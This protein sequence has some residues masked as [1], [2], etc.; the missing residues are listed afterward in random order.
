MQY[1]ILISFVT[2]LTF[3]S[4]SISK[5]GLPASY[6]ALSARWMEWCPAAGLPLWSVV[7]CL[8]AAL[9][10]PVLLE[11]GEGSALQFLGF[12]CPL[13]LIIVSLTPRW[14][15]DKRQYRV[16]V[17]GAALCAVCG[18]AWIVV[19]KGLWLAVA[20][21]LAVALVAALLTKTLRTSLVLW[22]EYVMFAGMYLSL[23]LEYL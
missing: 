6:S 18:L 8:V 4:L 11:Q 22:G 2:F 7:T 13:Y 15:T 14:A 12:F 21:P 23:F 16:H 17:W 9:L 10:M 1:L 19:V 5:W 20:G 3:N